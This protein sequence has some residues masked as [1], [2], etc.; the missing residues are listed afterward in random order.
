MHSSMKSAFLS[1]CFF[2]LMSCTMMDDEAS[3]GLTSN[4]NALAVGAYA[5][6]RLGDGCSGGGKASL[7]TSE[8]L[9]ELSSLVS[10]DTSVLKVVPASEVPL[11]NA[12]SGY[13]AYGVGP[14]EAKLVASGKFDDGSVRSDE[15][16]VAVRAITGIRVVSYCS[17]D[18]SKTVRAAP[19]DEFAFQAFPY[20]ESEPLGG[21]LPA[22][23]DTLPGMMHACDFYSHTYRIPVDSLHGLDASLFSEHTGKTVAMLHTLAIADYTKAYVDPANGPLIKRY[24]PG[25][26]SMEVK[27]E[28]AGY[29]ICHDLGVWLQSTTPDVCTGIDGSA[30]WHDTTSGWVKAQAL[31]E[32]RCR[33]Q[34]SV[35]GKRFFD[36]V[37]MQV[38]IVSSRLDS[39]DLAG[40]GNSCATEGASTCDYG[41][42]GLAIC[43]NGKWVEKED[44]QTQSKTCDAL[45]PETAGCKSGAECAVCRSLR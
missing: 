22:L 30:L 38:F 29:P 43:K 23:L 17:S 8:S 9:V 24:T 13:Y 33:I 28:V 42:D 18:S 16:G 41:Y 2:A 39:F 11:P 45:P 32:G 4:G 19:G 5:P 44:C 40:Y 36:T 26:F 3:V 7:C 25:E 34:V 27:V 15:T 31:R 1:T 6:I 14:G 20:H 10:S 12:G 35:D 37:E 21:C